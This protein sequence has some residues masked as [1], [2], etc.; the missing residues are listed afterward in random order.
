MTL[1]QR[2]LTGLMRASRRL[3]VFLIKHPVFLTSLLLTGLVVGVRQIGGIQAWELLTYDQL[4]RLRPDKEPDPR[5]LIVA[6]TEEDIRAQ[7]R[8]PMSDEVIAKLLQRLQQYKPRTIGLDIYRDIPQPPGHQALL[9]QLQAPNVITI[10]LLGNETKDAVPAPSEVPENQVGLS[11]IVVDPDVVVRRSLLFARTQDTDFYSFAL[12]LAL[13]YLNIQPSQFKVQSGESLQIRDTTFP[14]LSATSGGY[15]T[16]DDRG[17]QIML[18]YRNAKNVARQVTLTQVLQ[19]KV[20]PAWIKDKMVLIGTT[21]PSVR[22]LFLTPYNLSSNKSPET[23]GVVIHAQKTS[24]LL[25]TV[26]DGYPLIWFWNDFT[27]GIWIWLWAGAGALLGWRLRH[28]ILLGIAVGVGLGGLFTIGYIIFLQ[29][30]W[31]PFVPAAIAF[32]GSGIAVVTY[33]LL[34]DALHDELTGLPNRALFV[35]RLQTVINQRKQQN[36]ANEDNSFAVLLLGL[37]SFKAINDSFGHR[38]ADEL[39]VS[40]ANRIKSCLHPRDQMARVGGDEFAILL[41][42]VRDPDEVAHLAN[43]LQKQVKVPMT[44][45]DQDIVTT[46]SVGIVLDQPD[47]QY[48]P[49]DVLRDAH[50]AMNQA[51]AAGKA[52]YQVFRAGMRVQ[53]MTRMQLET[54]LRRA[55]ERQEF[56]LHYQ[57]FVRLETGAI[58]GFEALLRWQHPQRGFVHPVEFI[59]VAEETDLILPIGQWVIEEACRQLKIWQEQFSTDRLLVSVNLSSK[60]FSQSD[61]VEQIEQVLDETGLDGHSLKLEIT[62]SIAM[63]DV[64]STI[65]LLMRLKALNLQLSIDDFGTGYSSLSYLHRFPTDTIK[66]DR[67]FVSRIGDESEDAH[68]VQ[69]IIMLG[70][71]LGMSI[72]AEGVE[73]AD[74][75]SRLRMLNCEYAQGYFFSKPAPSPVVE[76]LLKRNPHW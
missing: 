22:D 19:G 16:L 69:T 34:Y 9:K 11:D 2:R 5:L 30:G 56:Q 58:A 3:T 75:L 43:R 57:P 64:E 55:I 65:A 54:D 31:I 12:R 67:S 39:L 63:T 45:G 62:E 18:N 1:S 15:E 35:N 37:D 29:A 25:A 13:N 71:N 28:P 40:V 33:R 47:Q 6:I 73:T 8:W 66:V 61:L 70:H 74:Q 14:S 59:P 42:N 32:V 21:A 60:Q 26:L 72:V 4:V 46:A 49:E 41:K 76:A 51:K 44:L 36:P 50:T 10:K 23:P 38:T 24:Q 20:E 7:N 52:R 68:I 48:A 17:Y 27:E 53:V